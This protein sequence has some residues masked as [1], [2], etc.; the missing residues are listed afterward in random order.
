[1]AAGLG[2]RLRPLTDH[3]PKALVEYKGSPLL[4]HVLSRLEI[5]GFNKVVVNVHHLAEQVIDY[6]EGYK[7][8]G[9]E[10]QISNETDLL[11]DTGGGLKKAGLFFDDG[12]VLVH[13]VDI[14]T[15]LDLNKLWGYH[16]QKKS[17]ATLAVK[18]RETSRYLLMDEERKLCGWQ[19]RD[20]GETIMARE[21][22]K[23]EEIA[24]SAIYVVEKQFIE[25]LPSQPVFPI[26]PEILRLAAE[27]DI[28]LFLHSD[29][30]KD[31]GKVEAY[32]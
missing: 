29:E 22:R 25:L 4:E 7:N 13:N 15:G 9:M 26:M 5:H 28:G 2:T 19:K 16:I 3:K 30:W 14:L 21:N 6:L 32:S 8:S 18:H 17:I 10:I 1:M 31:M 27:Y 24:F 23:V 11:R 20:T 12:P